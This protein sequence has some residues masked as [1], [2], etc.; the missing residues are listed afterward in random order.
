MTDLDGNVLS[1]YARI[2]PFGLHSHNNDF[3]LVDIQRNREVVLEGFDLFGRL[4]IPPGDYEFD[5]VRAEVSTGNQRTL[6]VVLSVQGGGFFGG[7]RLQ[8]FIELQ[9]RQSAHFSLAAIFEENDVELHSG[10]FVSHLAS[11]RTDVA[12]NSDWS[13]STP[14][15]YNNTTDLFGINSRLRY[16]PQAGQEIILVFNHNADVGIDN[17][18]TTTVNDLTLTPLQIDMNRRRLARPGLE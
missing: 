10:S 13:W 6:S 15:Q 4:N 8:K 5:R 17:R 12:F 2:R 18:L 3:W 11:L 7:D 9:W 14:V 16:T 1:Q